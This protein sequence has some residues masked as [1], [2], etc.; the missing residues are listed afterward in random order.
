MEPRA[1]A[2]SRLPCA[3]ASPAAV[4]G[5]G[6]GYFFSAPELAIPGALEINAF[7]RVLARERSASLSSTPPP[8]ATYVC[9]RMLQRVTTERLAVHEPG[10]PGHTWHTSYCI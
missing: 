10:R 2:A 5:L 7:I 1:E 9:K 8:M 4:C 3:A 6:V